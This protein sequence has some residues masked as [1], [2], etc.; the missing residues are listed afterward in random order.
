MPSYEMVERNLREAMRCYS[1]CTPEGEVREMDGIVIASSGIDYSV[2]NSAMFTTPVMSVFDLERRITHA[3]VHF[4]ARGL[5]WSCWVCEDLLSPSVRKVARQ[6][7]TGRGMRVVAQPPGMYADRIWPR[8][9]PP[10]NIE[11]RRVED[12]RTRFD[13]ADVASIVFSLPFVIS[14][15]ILWP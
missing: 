12:D 6:A 11:F 15:K 14:E 1:H 7:F 3:E 9:R 5:G 8:D 2:F 10:A 13:F 4:S